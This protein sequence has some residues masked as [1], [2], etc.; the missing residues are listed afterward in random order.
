MT[1]RLTAASAALAALIP[2]TA[3]QAQDRAAVPRSD[4]PPEQRMMMHVN[5]VVFDRLSTLMEPQDI[6]KLVLVANQAAVAATCEGYEIDSEAYS[7]VMGTILAPL[8]ALVPEGQENLPL[9]IAMHG[10][11]MA[12]GGWMARAG[13]DAASFC[14]DAAKMT[15]EFEESDSAR[16]LRVWARAG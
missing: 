5:A 13:Y 7:R 2:V 3:A 12:F 16:A 1:A 9:D 11:A 14:A 4:V 8:R 15:A 6:L 10:Y